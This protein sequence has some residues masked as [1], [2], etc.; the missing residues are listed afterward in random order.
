MKTLNIT[1]IALIAMLTMNGCGGSGGGSPSNDSVTPPVI[2]ENNNTVVIENTVV[3]EQNTSNNNGVVLTLNYNNS[4]TDGDGMTDVAEIKYGYDPDDAGSFPVVPE[5]VMPYVPE[6]VEI[7]NSEINAYV[8]MSKTSL[9]INWVNTDTTNFTLTLDN[10]ADRIYY[11][12]H[13]FAFAEVNYV[14]LNITGD[15]VLTGSFTESNTETGELVNSYGTFTI[16]LS[17]FELVAKTIIGDINNHISFTYE[18]FTT[19]NEVIYNNFLAK[20]WPIMLDRL[21]PPA[22]NFNC[23]I[24]SM[25]DDVPYFMVVDSGR[26]FLSTQAFIPRLMVHEFIHAWKGSYLI[27]SD[28][29]WNYDTDLNGFEEGLAEGFAFEIIHEFTRAFPNDPATE[30]LLANK[31][32]QYNS[33]YANHYDIVKTQRNTTSGNFWTITGSDAYRYSSAAVSVQNIAREYPSFYADTQALIYAEINADESWRPTRDNIIDIW[34]EVAPT[35]QGTE[36]RTYIDALP[37]FAGHDMEDGFYIQNLSRHNG[38][39]GDQQFSI[40]YALNGL[41]W[42]MLEE[43]NLDTVTIPN[44]VSYIVGDDSWVYVDMQAQPY[45]YTVHTSNEVVLSSSSITDSGYTNGLPNGLGWDQ[46][47]DLSQL[48]YPTGLYR[49]DMSFDNFTDYNGSSESFYFFGYNDYY[50]ADDESA[51]MVGIDTTAS[52]LNM[53]ITIDGLVATDVVENS[54]GLF[55]FE[56]EIP[57]GY[58][59]VISIEVANHDNTCTYQ[60]T[61]LDTYTLWNKTEFGYVIIDNDFNCIEDIY[62]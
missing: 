17:D 1:T 8:T 46:P 2:V 20:V 55:R 3:T 47:A 4:D 33:A 38:G 28:S 56:N 62:E 48:E 31:A 22:E 16:N 49:V 26:I 51:I 40:S 57:K 6:Q 7:P 37:V 30:Q 13:D 14:D 61:L 44:E 42:W 53:T 25:G 50:L 19:E 36:L 23:V 10:G 34:S 18:G 15:E 45:S 27:A 29:D 35:V 32:H 24:T 5:L 41:E 21:G 52:D 54:M 43:I 11:G 9:I 12:G 58:E 59:A 39:G 60:R